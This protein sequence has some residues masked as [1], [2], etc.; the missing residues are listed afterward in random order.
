MDS[1]QLNAQHPPAE[2]FQWARVFLFLAAA[3]SATILL[4]VGEIQYLELIYF[5]QLSLLVLLFPR[6]GFRARLFR[7]SFQLGMLYAVFMLV[8]L[9]SAFAALR[10]DFYFPSELSL[11]KHPIWITSSRIAELII[12]VGAMM[13]LVQLF[14]AD[15]RNLIFTLRVYYWVGVAGCVYS[16]ISFPL[17]Y[18]YKLDLGT[19][20]NLHRMR[21]FFNEASP[22]GL[23][24]LGEILIVMV[25]RRQQW[26]TRSQFRW[27][28]PLILIGLVVSQSKAAI[29]A[30]VLMLVFNA[31]M[32]RKTSQRVAV[33]TG[34][35][36][37]CGVAA[38]VPSVRDSVQGYIEKPAD[39]EYI[40]N[41][42]YSDPNYIY[43]KVAGG[44]LVPRMIQAH[45]WLGVGWGNY[46]LVRDSPQYRG[47]SAFADFYDSPGLGLFGMAA[48][49]GVPATLFLI[50]I[51]FWP[52]L[53]LRRIGAPLVVKNIALIQ[54]MVHIFGGQLNMT[55][56]WTMTAFAFALGYFYSRHELSAYPAPVVAPAKV[57]GP[58]AA[59]FEGGS[60]VA[61]L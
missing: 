46:G 44:F 43:G 60:T 12:D 24:L 13:Y 11:L 19:Y 5:F 53:Y 34:V 2:R 58:N 1:L 47:G 35:L 28:F 54:P 57:S 10:N 32:V 56:P 42:V 18:F 17:N 39:F 25:L 23:Y 7:P 48:E 4:K 14:R 20:Y 36:V 15:L 45:P 40:S 6:R 3:L 26:I 21:G 9:L 8:T 22:F 30:V 55:Y 61:A 50:V 49:I 52:Y 29:F 38:S 59:G 41:F 51:F 27:T 37:V 16:I 33:L 31:L